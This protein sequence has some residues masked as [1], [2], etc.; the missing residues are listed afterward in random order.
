VLESLCEGWGAEGRHGTMCSVRHIIPGGL[1]RGPH[2]VKRWD[3]RVSF[4]RQLHSSHA[5]YSWWLI[6]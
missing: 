6:D 2:R 5:R 3:C 4:I 1:A